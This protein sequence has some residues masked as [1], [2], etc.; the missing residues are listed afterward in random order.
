MWQESVWIFVKQLAFVSHPHFLFTT[1]F[2]TPS[3]ANSSCLINFTVFFS[4]LVLNLHFLN[5]LSSVW[6]SECVSLY[7]LNQIQQVIAKCE[8]IF[9]SLAWIVFTFYEP[10]H[11]T[12]VQLKIHACETASNIWK[13]TDEC[14]FL[15]CGENFHMCIF[16][17]FLK[18]PKGQN[19]IKYWW[20]WHPMMQ[21]EVE[22]TENTAVLAFVP[23]ILNY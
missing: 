7:L 8:C 12:C 6:S 5:F 19:I 2:F 3:P 15:T 11:F 10:K 4:L 22:Y 21:Q 16:Y 14:A 18:V 1:H 20:T 9:S 13:T 23:L 17:S